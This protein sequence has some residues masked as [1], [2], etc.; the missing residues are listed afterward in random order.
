MALITVGTAECKVSCDPKDILLTH[1]VG[2]CIALVLY[3]PVAR[4][5]GLLHFML[6][7]S[8]I[9][10]IKANGQPSM[11]ADT[12]IPLLLHQAAMLG[13][14]NSR[15]T[16]MAAGAASMLEQNESF[17][18]GQCNH[19]ALAE[20]FQSAGIRLQAQHLGGTKAR[21]LR[22]DV[23]RGRVRIRKPG[24]SGEDEIVCLGQTQTGSMVRQSRPRRQSRNS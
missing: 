5:A 16:F 3:D 13:A 8:N 12:G 6:P 11:Y 9:D 18:V 14:S 10:H 19:R 15:L 1:A 4:V 7:D 21:T 20:I 2:S 23:A 22:V 24:D 17:H